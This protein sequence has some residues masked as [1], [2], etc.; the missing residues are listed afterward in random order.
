M[1]H[2]DIINLNEDHP[3]N[4]VE[5]ISLKPGISDEELKVI[6]WIM[7]NHE[8]L[9]IP[10]YEVEPGP[11]GWAKALALEAKHGG[12]RRLSCYRHLFKLPIGIKGWLFPA[13]LGDT[14]VV[15]FRES[16]DSMLF[17]TV[18]NKATGKRMTYCS[19]PGES[20]P[21]WANDSGL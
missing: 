6:S 15:F 9:W 2:T 10:I 11:D 17:G 20:L 7:E 1:L 8:M 14:D 4:D 16:E 19:D 12:A 3:V 5:L 21:E 18:V 13:H